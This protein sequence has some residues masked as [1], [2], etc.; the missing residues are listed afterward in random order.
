[1]RAKGNERKVCADPEGCCKRIFDPFSCLM[2]GSTNRHTLPD[3]FPASTNC[4]WR[5]RTRSCIT[6]TVEVSVD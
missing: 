3:F 6:S 5:R 2:Y 4:P 1:M